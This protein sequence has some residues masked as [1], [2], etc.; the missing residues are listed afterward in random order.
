[1]IITIKEDPSLFLCSCTTSITPPPPSTAALRSSCVLAHSQTHTPFLSPPHP[2][3]PAATVVSSHTFFAHTILH[4]YRAT[5]GYIVE[6]STSESLRKTKKKANK[7]KKPVPLTR[8]EVV[9]QLFDAFINR[10]ESY[11][12][13][14]NHVGLVLFGTQVTEA[15]PLSNLLEAFRSRV[16]RV[17]AK[18][19]TRLYDALE[20]AVDMLR[21]LKEKN[22]QVGR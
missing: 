20:Q 9:K 1:M 2:H 5:E 16:E 4:T 18:G 15:F 21:K 19:D 3:L 7:K 8:I 10:L 22:P 14:H 17:K 6:A 11:E 12:D 13:Y